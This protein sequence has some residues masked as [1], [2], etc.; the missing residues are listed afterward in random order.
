MLEHTWSIR[1][2]YGETDQMGVV[3][4]AHYFHYFEAAR[5]ELLR[6]AGLPYA[7]LE[8]RGIFLVVTDTACRYRSHAVYDESLRIVTRVTRLRKATVRFQYAVHGE[9]G[10]LVAEG[11]TDLAAV[12]E[13]KK[14]VRLPEDVAALLQ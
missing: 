13:S 5:T 7:R 3:Y 8:K 11:H 2:R 14:P 4:H 6:A 12:D 1:V 10:R 9:D